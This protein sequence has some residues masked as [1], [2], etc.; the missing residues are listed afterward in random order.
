MLGYDSWDMGLLAGCAYPESRGED[1]ALA[2]DTLG[3][4]TLFDDEFD[5]ARGADPRTVHRECQQV[6]RLAHDPR[7][8]GDAALGALQRAFTGLWSRAVDGMPPGWCHRYRDSWRRSLSG[9]VEEAEDRGRDTIPSLADYLDKRNRSLGTYI[10][11][12]LIERVEDCLLPD[13][14]WSYPLLPGL[15]RLH[16]E[17]S[18]VINDILSLEREI[19]LGEHPANNLVLLLQHEQGLTRERAVHGALHLVR[20]KTAA[21]A[22]LHDRLPHFAR[23]VSDSEDTWRRLVRY[24]DLLT[25]MPRSNYDWG[26]LT[27]RYPAAATS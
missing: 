13:H 6:L 4:Y 12:D 2:A 27:G 23:E 9:M 21:I 20:R 15:R 16:G 1:L 24:A 19:V 17:L 10:W 7:P 26:L 14:I 3:W 18:V 11:C 8:D 5:G 25:A 22:R